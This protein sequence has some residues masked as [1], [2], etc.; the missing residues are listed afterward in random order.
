MRWGG[1]SV[2]SARDQR[3]SLRMV[4]VSGDIAGMVE[5]ASR[6]NKDAEA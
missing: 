1:L 5:A 4:R 2:G 6:R 3:M